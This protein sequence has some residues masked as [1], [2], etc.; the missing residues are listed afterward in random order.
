MLIGISSPLR[1]ISIAPIFH[2]IQVFPRS[3]NI[4]RPN[5]IPPFDISLSSNTLRFGVFNVGDYGFTNILILIFFNEL[6]NYLLFIFVE[7]HYR[8]QK[9]KIRRSRFLM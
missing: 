9:K 7:F 3:V 4:L 5:L 2:R 8:S 6:I 1:F